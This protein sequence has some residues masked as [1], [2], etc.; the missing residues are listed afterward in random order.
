VWFVKEM[1]VDSSRSC[2]V[3]KVETADR[4]SEDSRK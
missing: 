1:V 2:E 4:W 3:E